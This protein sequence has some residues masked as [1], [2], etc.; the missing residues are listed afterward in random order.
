MVRPVAVLLLA[1]LLGLAAPAWADL[2]YVHYE[3][4]ERALAAG[5]WRRAVEELNQALERKADSGRRVRSYG[6]KVVD[7][8]PYLKLGIAYHHL[9]Q[10]TAAREAFDTEVRLGVVDQSPEA[11]R[12][13]ERYQE[14]AKSIPPPEPDG[15]TPEEITREA[16]AASR[17]FETQGRLDD[18]MTALAPALALDPQPV[19]AREAMARLGAAALAEEERARRAATLGRQLDDARQRLAAGDAPAAAR[20]LREVLLAGENAEAR[21]LLDEAQAMIV[22]DSSAA[23]RR[24]RIDGALTEAA[25]LEA[26]GQPAAALDRL[27]TVFALEATNPAA[28]EQRTRLTA[29]LEA[30]A[31]QARVTAGL[32][33]A[34]DHLA[35]G[36]F[37][38]AL[39]AANRVLA[40]ERGQSEALVLVRQAYSEISRRLLAAG[41]SEAVNLPPALRFGGPRQE[42]DGVLVEVTTNPEFRLTGVAIDRSPVDVR[43]LDDHGRPLVG[44][45]SSQAV[46]DYFV[47]ELALG[48]QLAAGDTTVT[49]IATDA[50][51]QSSRGEYTVRYRRPWF[52]SPWPWVVSGAALAAGGV[53][54]LLRRRRRRRHQFERRFNPFIAGAPIFDEALFY[55]REPLLQRI[56][57][58]VH[59]NSLLLHGERRIGKTSLLHQ[60]ERRLQRLDDPEFTFVPVFVDLQG[61][62]EERLFAALA[63]AI[64]DVLKAR[65]LGVPGRPSALDIVQGGGVY[66]HHELIRE[67]H[68][69][70]KSL[71]EASPKRVKLVLLIDEVDELNDYDSRVSQNLRSLF[72]KRFAENLV[73]V[74]AGV[75][76]RKEWEKEGSPWYNF[77]EEIAVDAIEPEPAR[78]L[79]VEPVRGLFRFAPGVPERIVELAGGRPFQIQRRCL[80]LVQR[81]HEEKRRTITLE[82]VETTA[83]TGVVSEDGA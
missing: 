55:G 57:Q 45:T 22:A 2:W 8:F 82:D 76:I 31:Q 51:G 70:L 29:A 19:A 33:S 58:T 64:H 73:A 69:W 21:R 80:A 13:L 53:F 17:Q 56:L 63:D 3:N 65:G 9:G 42:I 26:S 68:G 7:Y 1:F 81:L 34:R 43:F 32:T 46:G 15:P 74:V 38:A 40:V 48:R 77:F 35:A 54:L 67:L 41:G 52:R 12:E 20:L 27:E 14:L 4:A 36:R 39:S 47:T 66:S 75:R 24:A 49:V 78:R 37:E 6:M 44:T 16:L 10:A 5:E 18:A 30:S 50:E 25:Q 83:P 28:R 79:V 59:N 72:M 62:P 60:L 11:R 61:T 71:R 23:E